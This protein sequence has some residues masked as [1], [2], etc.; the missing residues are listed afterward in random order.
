MVYTAAGR[1]VANASTNSYAA[2]WGAL[3][4]MSAEPQNGNGLFYRNSKTNLSRE[5]IDGTSNTL[6]IA[7]R[8]GMFAQAPWVGVIDTGAVV[9]TPDAPVYRS[10]VYPATVMVTARVGNKSLNDPWSEPDDFFTPHTGVMNA[11]YADGSVRAVSIGVDP[12]VF[13]AVATRA[14]GET[15]PLPE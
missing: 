13:Q 4:L 9:T 1:K 10:A 6:A 5:V 3:G 15:L 8:P 7:E 12:V 11:L 14:G 2:C